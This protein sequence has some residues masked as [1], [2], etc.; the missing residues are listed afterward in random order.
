MNIASWS[1]LT[2]YGEAQLRANKGIWMVLLH[3]HPAPP[4]FWSCHC[5]IYNHLSKI[6]EGSGLCNVFHCCA[7]ALFYFWRLFRPRLGAHGFAQGCVMTGSALECAYP[8]HANYDKLLAQARQKAFY[9]PAK[10]SIP[11]TQSKSDT[12][13]ATTK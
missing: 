12:V 1:R 2:L 7:T 10:L 4:W 13:F 5:F 11:L 6:M 8:G 9:F 3:E